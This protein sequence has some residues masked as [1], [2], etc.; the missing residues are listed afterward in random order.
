MDPDPDPTSAKNLD[1]DP[2]LAEIMD[3]DPDPTL[4]KNVDPDPTSAKIMDPD[5]ILTKIMDPD[6]TLAKNMD[7]DLDPTQ[8]RPK[9][10]K[11]DQIFDIF[12][13]KLPKNALCPK[14]AKFSIFFSKKYPKTP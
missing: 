6:P 13:K 14:M 10:P 1:P 5:P 4:A 9:M 11:N 3:P 8:K 2:T 12:L 7:P